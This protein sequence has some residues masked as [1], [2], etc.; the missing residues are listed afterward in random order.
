[1]RVLPKP[2]I[3]NLSPATLTAVCREILPHPAF[4]VK[5]NSQMER[6]LPLFYP[7]LSRINL[8]GIMMAEERK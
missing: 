3:F 1:M 7:A 6:A 2:L 8:P 5:I 4:Y